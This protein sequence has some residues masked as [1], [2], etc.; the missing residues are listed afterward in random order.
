[1]KTERKYGLKLEREKDEK[2]RDRMVDEREA[3]QSGMEM[4]SRGVLERRKR[5]G[6]K[7]GHSLHGERT[8]GERRGPSV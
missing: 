3:T 6:L 1:L 4:E 7:S 8:G 2:M 5:T